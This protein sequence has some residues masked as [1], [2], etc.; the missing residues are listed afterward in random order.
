MAGAGAGAAGTA[1]QQLGAGVS[2]AFLGQ[3]PAPGS[4][5]CGHPRGLGKTGPLVPV[6]PRPRGG[7]VRLKVL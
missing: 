3:S 4:C 5:E 2:R 6:L 7:S 1:E